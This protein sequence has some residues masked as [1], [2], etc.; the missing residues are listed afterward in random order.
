MD[1]YLIKIPFQYSSCKQKN[2]KDLRVKTVTLTQQLKEFLLKISIQWRDKNGSSYS[3]ICAYFILCNILILI[4]E[5]ILNKY[6]TDL[7]KQEIK[8]L[9]LQLKDFVTKNT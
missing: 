6:R 8:Y 7:R 2:I 3:E 9:E 1:L 5:N 4:Y